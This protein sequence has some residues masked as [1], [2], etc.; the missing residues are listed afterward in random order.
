MC[1]SAAICRLFIAK[2]HHINQLALS[3]THHVINSLTAEAI[4]SFPSILLTSPSPVRKNGMEKWLNLVPIQN[5]LKSSMP[6]VSVLHLSSA[7]FSWG[8]PTAENG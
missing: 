2:L 4:R 7:A 5:L 3:T 6:T 1:F 8:Q